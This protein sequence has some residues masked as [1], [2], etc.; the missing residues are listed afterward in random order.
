MVVLESTVVPDPPTEASDQ[1]CRV[2]VFRVEVPIYDV[3]SLSVT[4][5]GQETSRAG[6]FPGAASDNGRG[7]GIE[8]I[9]TGS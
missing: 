1:I 5:Y 8:G 4:R 3:A 9:T 2:P 6:P 7:E